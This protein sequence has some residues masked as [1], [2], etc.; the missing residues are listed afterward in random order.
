MNFHQLIDFLNGI[1]IAKNG[2]YS[3][4]NM[5]RVAARLNLKFPYHIIHVA[6]TN[7][8]GSICSKLSAAYTA[9]GY[10]TGC[11]ISPHIYTIRERI[12]INQKNISE[13]DFADCANTVLKAIYSLD[14]KPTFF[15]LV[16]LMAFV[17]F[18]LSNIDIAIIET[19]LGGRLDATNI[20]PSDLSIITSIQNDHGS[21]L[22]NTLNE[23]AYEKA[24]IIKE[25]KPVIYAD[26]VCYSSII[27]KV[28]ETR[29]PLHFLP[30]LES[31]MAKQKMILDTAFSI[32]DKFLPLSQEARA[33]GASQS[34][35]CRME[36]R[37][38]LH[39]DCLFDNA[40]N[41]SAM[42]NLV[43]Q[44]QIHYPKRKIQF[45][46]GLSNNR[47]PEE[48]LFPLNNYKVLIVDFSN[49]RM[50]NKFSVPIHQ[51]NHTI[52]QNDKIEVTTLLENA[53]KNDEL[54]VFTGSIYLFSQI[55]R[56]F[57]LEKSDL[58]SVV[59]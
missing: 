23:I 18:S 40:H 55:A 8:K 13:E 10:T 14:E 4:V 5:Q 31:I 12:Q 2:K 53:K 38:I 45:V 57:D 26:D 59:C 33:I 6:G 44:L 32:M 52:A 54:V 37:E 30:R 39:V 41:P 3:I 15:E 36:K 49:P 24:G 7:G 11:F 1:A 35:P 20:V 25:L 16:T 46:V 43:D 47:D 9:G 19:G 22:G 51:Q 56:L 48:M 34:V 50:Q 27:E 17:Y 29:S 58:L 42:Q 21:I 28:R